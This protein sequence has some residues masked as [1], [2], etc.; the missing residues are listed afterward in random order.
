MTPIPLED[1]FLRYRS[2]NDLHALGQVFDRTAPHLLSLARRLAGK[3]A[4]D[5]LQD[6]FLAAIENSTAWDAERP[7]VPWLMGIL[8]HRAQRTWK[9]TGRKPDPNRLPES[10]VQTPDNLVMAKEFQASLKEALES[11]SPVLRQTVNAS[12]FEGQTPTQL[13]VN[14]GVE[15][16]TIRQRLRRGLGELRLALKGAFLLLFGLFGLRSNGLAA[17]RSQILQEAAKGGS[18]GLVTTGG[19]TAS[20][21]WAGLIVLLTGFAAISRP[22]WND[23]E[24][25]DSESDMAT[26]VQPETDHSGDKTLLRSPSSSHREAA[27]LTDQQSESDQARALTIQ[28]RWQDSDQPAGIRRIAIQYYG[29]ESKFFQTDELGWLRVLL[30]PGD[31]PSSLSVMA[32]DDSPASELFVGRSQFKDPITIEVHRGGSLS[33]QVVDLKGEPVPHAMVQAW[34]GKYFRYPPFRT[35]EADKEGRFMLPHI[36]EVCII[37]HAKGMAGQRGLKGKVGVDE[38][39]A[40]HTLI[41]A[42]EATVAGIVLQPDG[43]PAVGAK[44]TIRHRTSQRS[45]W[46]QTHDGEIATFEAGSGEAVSDADGGFRIKGLPLRSH[47]AMVRLAP[48]LERQYSLEPLPEQ[49]SLQLDAGESF[50][51]TVLDANGLPVPEA[52]VCYWPYFGNRQSTPYWN[53]VNELD[54]TFNLHGM[55]PKSG[56]PRGLLVCAPGHAVLAMAPLPE[57]NVRIKLLPEK[58]LKG[59]V[60]RGN[61]APAV[62]IL[63]RIQG[64]RLLDLG[65]TSDTAH[66]WEKVAKNNEARTDAEGRFDFGGLYPGLFAVKVFA[67]EEEQHWLEQLTTS[68]A[69]E[70]KFQLT[71]ASLR[72]VVIRPEVLNGLTGKPIVDFQFSAYVTKDGRSHGRGRNLSKGDLGLEATGIEP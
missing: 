61:G 22:L 23:Q 41:V 27:S 31:S 4:D 53:A 64:D 57:P 20:A 46:Q 37:A 24:Q 11:L 16:G 17:M 40:G 29:Q 34:Q 14:L 55:L 25:P 72:K 68:G 1:L 12:L 38:E 60:T 21:R 48:F 56:Y 63:V 71:E 18:I 33:G 65:Y 43:T 42:P 58:R 7:L 30:A 62:N 47:S 35:V 70:L 66:T 44:L 49:N 32:T 50:S 5:V 10:E 13:A 28:V 36:S 45:A 19:A 59:R 9:E 54:G 69:A 52:E 26:L 3:Q 15:P 8:T 2:D 6:T 67:D 39:L 51:G